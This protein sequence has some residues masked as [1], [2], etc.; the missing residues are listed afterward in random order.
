MSR[1]KSESVIELV[2]LDDYFIPIFFSY[3]SKYDIDFSQKI[4]LVR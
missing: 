3:N 4:E 1:S 2:I